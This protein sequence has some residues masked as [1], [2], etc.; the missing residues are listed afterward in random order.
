MTLAVDGNRI[1]LILVIHSQAAQVS[2]GVRSRSE[3]L[4]TEFILKREQL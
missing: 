3:Q 4:E 1:P 2:G